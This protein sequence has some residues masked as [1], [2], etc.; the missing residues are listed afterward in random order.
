VSVMVF[1]ERRRERVT[2][3]VTSLIDVLFLL[4]LFVVTTGTFKRAGELELRLPESTTSAQPGAAGEAR[5]VEVVLTESGTLL[6]GGERVEMSELDG[7]LRMI[8]AS[9]PDGRVTIKAETGVRHG[10]VVELLDAVRTAGF[11]GVA[12]AT[13]RIPPEGPQQDTRAGS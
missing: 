2:L 10:Q 8:R 9:D 13:L 3:N 11:P 12:L 4:L 5:D 1:R 7:R 6:L